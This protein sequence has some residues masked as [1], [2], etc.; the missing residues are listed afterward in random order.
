M[1]LTPLARLVEP[2][3]DRS[4]ARRDGLAGV[5]SAA[6]GVVNLRRDIT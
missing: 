6:N 1:T 3:G 2:T 4:D 5:A